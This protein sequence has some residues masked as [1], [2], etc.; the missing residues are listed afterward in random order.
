MIV[1]LNW[2]Y[3]SNM[4]AQQLRIRYFKPKDID[5]LHE[6]DS[7]CFPAH[8]SFS[9]AELLFYLNHPKSITRV[10]VEPGRILG[11]VLAR[12]ERGKKAHLITLDVIPEA[13]KR[14]IGTRLMNE[15]QRELKEAGMQAIILEVSVDNI[16]AQKLYAGLNYRFI[17]CLPRYYHGREDAYQMLLT[18]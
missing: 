16:P 1:L 8:I 3:N 17:G 5:K 6:I 15:I 2:K 7:I 9:R 11:F 18:I 4:L 12:I 10:A 13:R 14:K